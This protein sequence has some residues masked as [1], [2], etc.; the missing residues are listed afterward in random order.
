MLGPTYHTLNHQAGKVFIMK[1]HGTMTVADMRCR[2]VTVFASFLY[3]EIYS[4]LGVDTVSLQTQLFGIRN[5]F[6]T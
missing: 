1:V 6:F 3:T 4:I 2:I 5:A